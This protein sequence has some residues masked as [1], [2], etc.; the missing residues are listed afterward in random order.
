MHRS[1]PS[2]DL[3]SMY[4]SSG[5]ISFMRFK[6]RGFCIYNTEHIRTDDWPP[7]HSCASKTGAF[8]IYNTE[9]FD[10]AGFKNRGFYIYNTEHI[11]T[12]GRTTGH[13]GIDDN[14]IQTCFYLPST[15]FHQ[16]IYISTCVF[17]LMRYNHLSIISMLNLFTGRL[18]ICQLNLSCVLLNA[19]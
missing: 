5:S 3:Y 12:A 13:P 9:H 6:N 2:C 17:Y 7:R 14:N 18:L 19:I 10:S 4:P 1:T 8:Y 11:D 15:L 16:D